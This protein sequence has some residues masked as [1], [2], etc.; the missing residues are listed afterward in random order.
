MKLVTGFSFWRSGF[1]PSIVFVEF[2]VDKM[3]LDR[4]PLSTSV[5]CC[6]LQAQLSSGAGTNKNCLLY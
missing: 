1:I 6:Q 3:A 2:V 5:F 4:F